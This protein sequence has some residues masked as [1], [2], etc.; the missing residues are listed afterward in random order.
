MSLAEDSRFE[1]PLSLVWGFK[2]G[3]GLVGLVSCFTGVNP[4]ETFLIC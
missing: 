4:I 1:E 3:I 2:V